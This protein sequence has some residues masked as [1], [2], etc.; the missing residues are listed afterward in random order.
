MKN[1]KTIDSVYVS[2]GQLFMEFMNYLQSD[3]YT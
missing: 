2:T 1:K 3:D